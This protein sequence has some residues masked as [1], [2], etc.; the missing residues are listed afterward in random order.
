VQPSTR[1]RRRPCWLAAL[2]AMALL[3][4][5]CGADGDDSE[6]AASQGDGGQAAEAPPEGELGD[7][8]TLPT[9]TAKFCGDQPIRMA[10]VDGF[11]ANSWRKIVRAEL[12]SELK[13]CTNVE[14]SYAQAGGDIQK[15]NTQINS[16]V[17]QGYD[18]ILT[19]D[20][21]GEQGLPAIR[22]AHDADI[23]IVPYISN[24]GGQEGEDYTAF[25]DEHREEV[26]K[27]FADWLNKVLDGKG[28]VIFMGGIP[29]NPSSLSFMEPTV[30]NTDPG[31]KW[32]QNTPVD[33]NW[34]PAQ[35][36]R[37]TAG[38]ISKYPQIDAFVSDYGAASVGQLRAYENAGEPHPP[39]ATLA[40]SNE[41]GCVYEE[42]KGEWPD[43]EMVWVEGT[44]RVVRWAARR[45]LATFNEISI[46]DP[47]LL[48]MFPFVDTTAGREPECRK[49]L[50]PDADLSSG[51]TEEELQEV[52][53]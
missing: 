5:A 20:D 33:T 23:V 19:Y 43:F 4:G 24:P 49:D 7:L 8:E 27:T 15:Y 16:F 2:M 35:Y 1:W 41:L 10:Q 42:Q 14:I 53:G 13:D 9:D 38:L 52:F 22:K 39:L 51:L 18:I 46:D 45:A 17:A 29:G 12:Q 21:F 6:Q 44:T 48:K 32:L 25:V 36:T 37:V 34:D 26:G 50:P 40:S 11:G 28:N 31:I 3:L 30:E 47:K